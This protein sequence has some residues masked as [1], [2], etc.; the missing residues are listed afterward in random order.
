MTFTHAQNMQSMLCADA[1][2][3]LR[4][5]YSSSSVL[6]ASIIRM[7]IT[8]SAYAC[9]AVADS[10]KQAPV[11]FIQGWVVQ[12]AN[13]GVGV[14]VAGH[15]YQRPKLMTYGAARPH[16]HGRPSMPA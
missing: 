15:L 2:R 7:L 16:R 11:E 8:A 9:Q 5:P 14:N 12:G 4:F 6:I 1:H 10:D 3:R 13:V